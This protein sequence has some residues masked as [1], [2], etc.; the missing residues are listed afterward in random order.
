[1]MSND[2]RQ[3]MKLIDGEL[4]FPDQAELLGTLDGTPGGWK[5]LALGLLEADAFRRELRGIA[6]SRPVAVVM[7]D[8]SADRPYGYAKR[9]AAVCVVGLIGL[10]LG[11]GIG[12]IHQPIA[13]FVGPSNP[14]AT[15]STSPKVARQ[16]T[17]K[18]VFADAELG[19]QAVDLPV[20]DADGV[21]LVE[22][23][24]QSAVPDELR[25]K[26]EAEGGVIHEERSYIPIALTNGRQG[27]APVSDVTVEFPPIAF[28]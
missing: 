19:A 13:T 24:Q 12:S 9:V 22:L 16:E 2:E 17:L 14:V 18:V 26:L 20:I 5:R 21:A 8:R 3:W 23:M 27:I 1:M 4:S 28:Q 15:P 6:P 11:I 25:R 10:A 7:P